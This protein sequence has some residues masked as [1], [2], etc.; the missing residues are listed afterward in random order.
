MQ[1]NWKWKVECSAL[2]ELKAGKCFY[3]FVYRLDVGKYMTLM[4]CQWTSF[5]LP[6]V[7]CLL[8]KK[9][10]STF[11]NNYGDKCGW[12]RDT[13][14]KCHSGSLW[15]TAIFAWFPR[16]HP[17][18]IATPWF[19]IAMENSLTF[20]FRFA[21]DQHTWQARIWKSCRHCYSYVP[22]L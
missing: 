11:V 16:N 18:P 3:S 21:S 10:F 17:K 19:A 6:C 13:I 12:F 7:L 2:V 8:S 5:F 9:N 1:K 15:N 4:R 20:T 22:K 14:Q